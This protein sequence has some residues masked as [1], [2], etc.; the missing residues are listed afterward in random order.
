[1]VKSEFYKQLSYS[2]SFDVS[3]SLR[4]FLHNVLEFQ[5]ASSYDTIVQ[6]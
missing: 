4:F 2:A 6:L 5:P 1:M 3:V